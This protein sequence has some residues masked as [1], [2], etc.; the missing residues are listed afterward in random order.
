MGTRD[1]W[2]GRVLVHRCMPLG[3]PNPGF[4]RHVSRI[5]RGLRPGR[6]L[7]V[8]KKSLLLLALALPV[9]PAAA[10]HRQ[11]PAIASVTSSGDTLLPRVRASGDRITLGL[12]NQIFRHT[13]GRVTLEAVTATGDNA[14]PTISSGGSMVAWDADCDLIGCLDSGRQIFL[15][16][17]TSLSQVTHDPTGT[18][19]NP[20]LSGRGERLAFESQG[21]L[22]GT[23]NP[24][25]RQVFVRTNDGLVTQVSTG[26]GA[27]ANASLNR[28]GRTLVFDS[29]SHPLSGADTGVAQVWLSTFE[30]KAPITAGLASSRLASIS[31]DGKL[32]T[33]E[34]RAALAGGGADMGVTQIFA[35]EVK[36]GIYHQITNLA[37]GCA[38]ASVD[39]LPGEWRVGFTC[40]GQGYVQ[41]VRANER[42]RMPIT[43]GDT[44]RAAVELGRHFMVVSTTANL[45]GSGT[46]PGH[47]VYLLNLFKLSV[48]PVPSDGFQF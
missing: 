29:T 28:S 6:T 47:Q 41:H 25:A 17:G 21:D 15:L 19:R 18:S 11:S 4:L 9:A 16:S 20:A 39:R 27:S 1:S 45:L 46:T 30:G 12:G 42:F 34:S 7:I 3:L 32:V 36:T 8:T 48:V 13:T 31:L 24:G 40:G 14:N 43:G 10:F 37:G 35:Y 22:G 33:F 38:N 26:V 44:A 23:G 2:R 5:F